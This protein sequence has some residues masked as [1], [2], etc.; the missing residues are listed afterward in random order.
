MRRVFIILGIFLLPAVPIV[1][2]VTGLL[3]S[4]PI[5]ATPVKLTVWGTADDEKAIAALTAKYR[6]TR[7]YVTVTY[8]KVREE[9]YAQQLVSAWA[10]GTGPDVFFAP[11]AW[12]GKMAQYAIP[13][14]ADLTV[15]QVIVSKGIIGT[16]SKVVAN[17]KTAPSVS[18]LKNTFVE[19]VTSDVIRDDQTWG[20]PLSMDT[21]VLYYNKDLTNNAKIF[22]PAATWSQ[23]QTQLTANKLTQTDDQGKLVQSGVALG[24]S[25]NVPYATDLLALLMMQNGSTM[26]TSDKQAHI[27]DDA[28]L[29]ALKFY[30]SFAQPQKSNYSWDATQT[31][32]RD[33]FLQ[34]K[35]GYYFGTLGDRTTI[36][37]TTLNWGVSPMLHI[38]AS[39]D[40]DGTTGSERYIDATRYNVAMVSK[41][42]VQAGRS[43]QAWNYV[44]FVTQAGN[45]SPYLQLTSQ[46]PAQRS[47]LA[48]YENNADLSVFAKQLLTAKSWY[49]GNDGVAVET[50][51]SQLI[52]A[53]LAGK[54]DL[55]ELLNRT[56]AQIQSTL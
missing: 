21:I 28:G 55:T 3:K 32:A 9:E 18:A 52:D 22:E 20:L 10:Q 12:I 16:S 25:N 7:S 29:Q 54:S 37:A 35:V 34:G 46:L 33:A 13:M 24:T 5:T 17:T 6:Q 49:R 42:S 44:E 26:V 47:L 4:A 38:R 51:L 8:T 50:Y 11:S 30:L 31:A 23:L 36:A 39:G 48:P 1:L 43:T 41:A 27:N 56:N 15:P 40:N 45:I 53:G 19:A 14:P 2:V